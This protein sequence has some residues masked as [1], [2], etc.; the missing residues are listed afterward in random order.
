MKY[1]SIV[2]DPPWDY[3]NKWLGRGTDKQYTGKKA[4]TPRGAAAN[5]QTLSL[6]RL[7]KLPVADWAADD[8]HLYLWTTNAFIF[9]AGELMAAWG[10]EYKT[11]L[12]WMKPGIGMGMFFRNNTEDVLFGVRGRLPTL[13]KDMP[14]GYRW[15]RGR[16]SEKPAAFYDLVMKA[17]PG[18]RLDVFA[19]RQRF[20]WDAWGNEVSSPEG[21]PTPAEVFG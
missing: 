3:R 13:R 5:Y 17:S 7:S 6:A 9:A 18:P 11:K 4:G 12:T 10:F 20:Y 8:C 16:H 1:A 14:T 21:L 15:P 2:V 19:R